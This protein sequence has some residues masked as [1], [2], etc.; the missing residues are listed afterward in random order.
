MAIMLWRNGYV[1]NNTGDTLPLDPPTHLG[2]SFVLYPMT[3]H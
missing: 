2:I 3:A 1:T